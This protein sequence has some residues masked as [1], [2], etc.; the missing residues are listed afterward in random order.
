MRSISQIITAVSLVFCLCFFIQSCAFDWGGEDSVIINP[1]NLEDSY[2]EKTGSNRRKERSASRGSYG[3]D[4][5]VDD[6]DCAE[7]C[8]DLFDDTGVVEN[9]L[10]LRVKTVMGSGTKSKG[11]EYILDV[12]DD[13]LSYPALT[14]IDG[15]SFRALMSLSVEHWVNLVDDVTEE[16]AGALLAWI[17]AEREVAETIREHGSDGNYAGF[18]SY[19]GLMNLIKEVGNRTGCDEVEDA[20]TKQSL[21][22]K[23]TF[24]CIAYREG[25]T[26]AASTFTASFNHGVDAHKNDIVGDLNK[27]KECEAGTS[28]TFNAKAFYCPAGGGSNCPGKLR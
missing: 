2:R 6:D 3:R 22:G 20:L 23:F 18:N 14:N 21:V 1:S 27:L 11:F 17:A 16:E 19:E 28:P 15:S 4:K 9:C 7:V 8:E 26:V 13:D 25:N 12:F 10:D 24:C 5:C